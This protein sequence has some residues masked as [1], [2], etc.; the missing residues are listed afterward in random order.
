MSGKP[1]DNRERR[2]LFRKNARKHQVGRNKGIAV[3]GSVTF[4]ILGIVAALLGPIVIPFLLVRVPG[5]AGVYFATAEDSPNAVI[6]FWI[7]F[8]ALVIAIPVGMVIYYA[9]KP[10][11][12]VSCPKCGSMFRIFKAET[13]SMCPHCYLLILMGNSAGMA[14]RISTCAYCGLQTGVTEDHGTFLC[15]NCGI[16]REPSGNIVIETT[17]SCPTCAKVVS[18]EAIYCIG[19]YNIL[20]N[21]FSDRKLLTGYDKDWEI[22]K[23]A[24]GH[25]YYAKAIVNS[26]Q[27]AVNAEGEKEIG[28]V[29]FWLT[30]L[31]TAL[32]SME[33]CLS[34]PDIRRLDESLLSEVDRTYGDVL[35]RELR[36]LQNSDATK[37]Y[38]KDGLQTLIDEPH[39]PPRRRVEEMLGE[40]LE[41]VGSIGTW[42]D[43]LLDVQIATKESIMHGTQK[44]RSVKSY[45]RL[46]QEADRFAAWRSQAGSQAASKFAINA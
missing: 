22:G 35:D 5:L 19:C 36:L 2:T 14:P 10:A 21:V 18:T 40:S 45:D 7:V 37:E 17:V 34:E 1:T 29:E 31:A 26:I 43:K 11:K 28:D 8:R 20:K 27:Q 44:Y 42:T 9:M 30:C 33:E 41:S 4:V 25:F 15:S 13:K 24:R 38:P 12:V 32:I 16:S 3:T 23:D 39:L 46:L 6:G